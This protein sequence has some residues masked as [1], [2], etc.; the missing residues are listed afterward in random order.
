[1][2]CFTIQRLS[3]FFYRFKVPFL[4]KLLQLVNFI[5]FNSYL[6]FQLEIHKSCKAGHRGIGLVIN[7]DTKLGKN[8]LVRAHVTIGKQYSTSGAPV[9]GNNV[10]IGDG[11][12]V[13]GEITVG[14]NSI[15]G[16][17]AVVT[18]NVEPYSVVVGIPARVIRIINE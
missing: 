7:K 12:K 8:V 11:A 18:K 14:D 10:Q 1:M 4:P 9:I 3:H 13:L 6:P 5:L 16:A 17:N 2:N 15:I